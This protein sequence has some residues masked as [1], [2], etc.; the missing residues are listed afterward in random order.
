LIAPKGVV[1]YHTFMVGS[2]AFGSPRNPNF[3]LKP[4][5]LA[6]VFSDFTV[7]LDEVVT[8]ADGRPMTMFVARR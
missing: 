1:L 2:Q 5:E 3:L 6:T 7:L 4:G 8:L